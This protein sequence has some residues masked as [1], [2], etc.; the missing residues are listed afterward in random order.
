MN[1]R[2][3]NSRGSKEPL[4]QT[5]TRSTFAFAFLLRRVP[6]SGK[7]TREKS[8]ENLIR[9]EDEES[10]S[11]TLP[12]GRSE[13]EGFVYRERYSVRHERGLSVRRRVTCY[14]SVQLNRTDTFNGIVKKAAGSREIRETELELRN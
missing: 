5:Y 3:P 13:C 2:A 7:A 1:S 11:H 9:D 6:L 12:R 14:L 8:R 10:E 4:W